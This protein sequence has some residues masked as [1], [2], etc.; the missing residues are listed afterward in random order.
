MPVYPGTAVTGAG[1]PT[2]PRAEGDAGIEWVI[3]EILSAP[4][5]ISPPMGRVTSC[6]V[7]LR[8]YIKEAAAQVRATAAALPA[9]DPRRI[10]AESSVAEALHRVDTLRPGSGLRSAFDCARGLALAARE[11][12]DHK[13]ALREGDWPC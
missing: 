12:R 13:E 9:D 10:A 3:R 2:P 8:A 1:L 6:T 11:L 7:M 5:H 4:D